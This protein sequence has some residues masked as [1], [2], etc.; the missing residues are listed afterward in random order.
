MSPAGDFAMRW[1][2]RLGY[3]VALIYLAFARP[4]VIS[5]FAGA[6]IALAGLWVR[7]AAAGHLHKHEQLATGGPYAFTRNP[8]YFG[9]AHIAAGFL[10]A[11]RFWLDGAWIAAAVVASY[12]GYFYRAVMRREEEELRARYAGA[13]EDYA[14]RV[15]LFLPRLSR[16][17]A[18]PGKFSREQYW[19]NREYQAALGVLA[20]IGALCLLMWM[21]SG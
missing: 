3:P 21:R 14:A 5:I 8:L 16:A 18:P 9:S 10:I 13:F 12:F 4:Q 1:R 17:G 2:V 15:P 19:K 11:G 20:G 6:A 7:A